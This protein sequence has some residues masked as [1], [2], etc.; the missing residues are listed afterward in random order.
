MK[1]MGKLYRRCY[2]DNPPSEGTL[3]HFIY[4]QKRAS[5]AEEYLRE[6]GCNQSKLKGK[7]FL[8]YLQ[9]KRIEESNISS[10]SKVRKLK[11]LYPKDACW[12]KFID[13]EY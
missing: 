13:S 12:H 9:I 3:E 7:V 2:G 6:K 10:E 8:K 5:E 11:A 4:S 1:K